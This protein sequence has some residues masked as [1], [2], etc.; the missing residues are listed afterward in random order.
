M[1]SIDGIDVS[2]VRSSA[3][4]DEWPKE[5]REHRRNFPR[6]VTSDKWAETVPVCSRCCFYKPI[7]EKVPIMDFDDQNLYFDPTN[8][9]DNMI[10]KLA[11][12]LVLSIFIAFNMF[13][14]LA[15]KHQVG[16]DIKVI[17]L[18]DFVAL[19]RDSWGGHQTLDLIGAPNLDVLLHKIT[20]DTHTHTL[21]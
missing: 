20:C 13:H 8:Y 11:T 6:M 17:C 3:N 21:K 9:N 10:F 7:G 19:G 16:F 4:D 18:H 1:M 5:R 2:L 14:V 12:F 15:Q